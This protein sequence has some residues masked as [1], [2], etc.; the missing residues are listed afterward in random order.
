MA[1]VTYK[2]S[3]EVTLEG[4]HPRKWIPDT[5]QQGLETG[6]TGE[7]AGNWEFEEVEEKVVDSSSS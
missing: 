5:I 7:T 3:F 1:L 4:S 6:E 2:V